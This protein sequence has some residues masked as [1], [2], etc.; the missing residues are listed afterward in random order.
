MS[1]HLVSA[2]LE[3]PSRL[4]IKGITDSVLGGGRGDAG[5]KQL[6]LM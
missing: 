1:E 5:I 3:V 4:F 6:G 2:L